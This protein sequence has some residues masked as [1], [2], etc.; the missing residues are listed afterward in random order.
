MSTRPER[1]IGI[2][3]RDSQNR[4]TQVKRSAKETRTDREHRSNEGK[5]FVQRA[6]RWWKGRER[7]GEGEEGEEGRKIRRS[8]GRHPEACTVVVI[9]EGHLSRPTSEAHKR[10]VDEFRTS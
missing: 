3:S 5:G 7:E 6:W 1:S 9:I 4:G 8:G 2:E 10:G